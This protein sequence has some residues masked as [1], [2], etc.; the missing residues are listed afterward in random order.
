MCIHKVRCVF[1]L[2][3]IM[4]LFTACSQDPATRKA[5]A[6]YREYIHVLRNDRANA[7]NHCV[8]YEDPFLYRAAVA[9][10]NVPY[11]CFEMRGIIK[12]SDSLWAVNAYVE[13]AYRDE[14]YMIVNYVGILDGRY[15]VMVNEE[16]IPPGLKKDANLGAV[17]SGD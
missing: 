7:I 4:I 2:L 9:D 12:L 14:G 11:Y 15:Q 8:H 17:I 1:V 3:A 10:V 6:F 5:E 13:S 16:Q